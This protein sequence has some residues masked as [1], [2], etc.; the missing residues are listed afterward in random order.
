MSLISPKVKHQ[1]RTKP[2][3]RSRPLVERLEDRLTPSGGML[4]TTFGTNGIVVTHFGAL[5]DDT[6][7]A[8][9]IQSDGK[10]VVVGGGG[11]STSQFEL[12]RYNTDGSL[13]TSRGQGGKVT[14]SFGTG[15]SHALGVALQ[16]D[17]RIV[18]VGDAFMGSAT[19]TDFAAARYNSDGSLDTTFGQG[20]KVTTNFTL[21]FA[22]SAKGVALQADGKIVVVGFTFGGTA[23]N[24]N[25]AVVRYS[26][27]G[28]LDASFGQGGKVSTNF[29]GASIDDAYA[30]AIQSDGKIVLA[31]TSNRI[32][33]FDFALARYNS[34]GSLDS[35]FGTGGLVTTDYSGGNDVAQALVIQ[36]DGK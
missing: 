27:D 9:A 16:S 7:N 25:F 8:L 26:A 34:D 19:G 23:T 13:D 28:S 6:G 33:N 24:D 20:G 11:P 32:G 10:I 30:V 29:S 2:A 5:S 17:G 14:T 1:R 18:V 35:T 4:D 3:R 36:A 31:G 21:N 15:A 12:A 22:D